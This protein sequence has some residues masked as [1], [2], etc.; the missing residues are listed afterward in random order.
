MLPVS[1]LRQQP[2][3]VEVLLVLIFTRLDIGF[4]KNEKHKIKLRKI[5][6]LNFLSYIITL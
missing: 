5:L 3:L 1:D 4:K 2:N 6:L